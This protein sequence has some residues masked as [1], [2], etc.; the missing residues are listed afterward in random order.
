MENHTETRRRAAPH[1][2]LALLYTCT[3]RATIRHRTHTEAGPR[4][5]VRAPHPSLPRRAPSRAAHRFNRRSARCPSLC[6]RACRGRC[7]T[8]PESYRSLCHEASES[9]LFKAAEPPS[10]APTP[11]HLHEL[12]RAAMDAAWASSFSRSSLRPLGL[13]KTSTRPHRS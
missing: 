12:R 4:P 2:N 10:H 1:R 9:R 6:T 5:P 11:S 3:R 13:S 8:T 7:R